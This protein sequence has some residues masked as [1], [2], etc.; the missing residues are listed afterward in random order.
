MKR[1]I[2]SGAGLPQWTAP[3]SHAV[4]VDD[5]CFLSGQLSLD[6]EGRYVPGT[7]GE[8]AQRAFANLFAAIEA[9]GFAVSDLA[10]VDVALVDLADLADV[11]AVYAAL[12][13]PGARPAR[14]VY[15]A[16]ALPYGGRVKV[17]GTC[18]RSR[19]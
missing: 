13:P 5:L 9:S 18:A 4:V 15:Q 16:A 7:A 10:F 12:F 17:M 11:N 14:T 8:E 1:Y 6:G 2:E 19:R 3:I